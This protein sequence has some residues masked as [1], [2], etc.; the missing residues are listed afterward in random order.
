[1]AEMEGGMNRIKAVGACLLAMAVAFM[2]MAA[3]ADAAREFKEKPRKGQ[4][5]HF[6]VNNE[7][8][9]AHGLVVNLSKKAIVITDSNTGFAGPF[10][11]IRGKG[12]KSITFSNPRPVVAP[13][14]DE[15]DGFDLVFR[16]YKA[17]LKIKSYWWL[18]EKGKRIGK[19]QSL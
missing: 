19:K 17:G 16:S 7:G 12:T 15:E 10:Q 2:V 3:P 18:D 11:N 14:S 8:V 5:G 6:F 13:A 4:A 1:M 9:E